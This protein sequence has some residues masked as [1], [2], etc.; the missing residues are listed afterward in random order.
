MTAEN[1]ETAKLEKQPLLYNEALI[2]IRQ[3]EEF[4]HHHDPDGDLTI[5][6]WKP[7][8]SS[9]ISRNFVE[10]TKNYPLAKV[11]FDSSEEVTE[12]EKANKSNSIFSLG[13]AVVGSML[14][15]GLL[16]VLGGTAFYA[17]MVCI[18]LGIAGSIYYNSLFYDGVGENRLQRAIIKMFFGRKAKQKLKENKLSYSRHLEL[19]EPFDILVELTRQ[20]LESDNVF[21]I[22]NEYLNTQG[23]HLILDENGRFKEFELEEYE[24]IHPEILEQKHEKSKHEIMEQI[25]L[26]VNKLKQQELLP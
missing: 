8:E 9:V 12:W 7:S 23:K 14:F 19:K 1:A 2:K 26:K 3:A 17:P 4:L 5:H 22:I 15:G 18:P 25:E 20:E 24:K 10:T 13:S 11:E 16:S 6:W 21:N